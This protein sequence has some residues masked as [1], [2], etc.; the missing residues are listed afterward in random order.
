MRSTY[1]RAQS[2][3]RGVILV[4]V[5]A[6]L[7][8]FAII[9]LTFVYYAE[10][11]AAAS[12]IFRD[13]EAPDRGDVD[14]DLLL[15]YFLNQL[16]FDCRNDTQGGGMDSA[17]RGYG[18]LRNMFSSQNLPAYCGTGRLGLGATA[19]NFTGQP[20]PPETGNESWNP[21]YTYP[22]EN[23]M[24][25]AAV[26]ARDGMVLIPS[27]YRPWLG[28]QLRARTAE[29]PDEAGL[30]VKNLLDSPGTLINNRVVNNDSIWMDLNFPIKIAPDGTRYKALFAPLITDLDNRINLAVHGNIHGP[31]NQHV[32]NQGWGRWEV[33]PGR[34]LDAPGGRLP[35]TLEWVNLL[36]GHNGITGRYGSDNRPDV[37]ANFQ[38]DRLAGGLRRAHPY[39]P[40]DFD[41]NA[42]VPGMQGPA[43]QRYYT[44]NYPPGYDNARDEE[45]YNLGGT[46][47]NHALF[48][49]FF[50]RLSGNDR[51]G[52]FGY[53][54]SN[55]EALLRYKDM[56]SPALTSEIFRLM[57][58]NF[59][60]SSSPDA[61]RRRRM[62]TT[63]SMDSSGPGIPPMFYDYTTSPYQWLPDAPYPIGG[64]VL[65][66]SSPQ[67]LQ[68]LDFA[69]NSE[70]RDVC[71][72]GRLDL[73]GL[74]GS[75][76]GRLSSQGAI[77]AEIFRRLRVVVGAQNPALIP[78]PTD[79][80][81]PDPQLDALR[82]LAQLAINIVDYCD[83]DGHNSVFHWGHGTVYGAEFPQVV[84]NEAYAE[85]ERPSDPAKEPR[86]VKVWVELY[87]PHITP[88]NLNNY[89]L[90]LC[91]Q[92]VVQHLQKRSN[93]RG[94]FRDAMGQSMAHEQRDPNGG[95]REAIVDDLNSTHIVP[96]QSFALLGSERV[97]TT[98]VNPTVVS[99]RMEYRIEPGQ[100]VPP[101]FTILLQKLAHTGRAHDSNDNPWV[102]VDYMDRVPV[103]RNDAMGRASWGREEPIRANGADHQQGGNASGVQ[104]TFLAQ[105]SNAAQAFS[106]FVHLDRAPV[107]V[108]EILHVTTN[109]P[110]TL[111]HQIVQGAARNPNQAPW[112]DSSAR[113]YRVLELFQCR[114]MAHGQRSFT[115]TDNKPQTD[116]WVQGARRI[117]DNRY[118]IVPSG[119]GR[120]DGS[121][122][123][124]TFWGIRPGDPLL[125]GVG[126]DEESFVRVMDTNDRN[127]FTVEADRQPSG[128][129]RV[130]S[131]DDLVPGKI[132]INTIWDEEIFLA[133][134]DPRPGA[135][136][137]DDNTARQVFQRM[138]TSRSPQGYPFAGDRP[139]KGLGPPDGVES[140]ILRP[141]VFEI[142]G[143]HEYHRYE[144]LT[145]IHNNITT[146]SNVFA[147]WVTVGFFEVG[148][149]GSIGREI[150][151]AE[152]RHVRHRMFAIIDRS[153]HR[154]G[155]GTFSQSRTY[156]SRTAVPAPEPPQTS[157][158]FEIEPNTMADAEVGMDLNVWDEVQ[159]PVIDPVTGIQTG[160]RTERQN[161]ET[162][163]IVAINGNRFTA[164]FTRGHDVGFK[165]SGGW[166]RSRNNAPNNPGPQLKF[167]QRF[168][169]SV[170]GLFYGPGIVP[171]YS[172]IE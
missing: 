41:G 61:A 167:N 102:T 88:K 10:S 94:T 114:D 116:S 5:M 53:R 6:M 72:S 172:I 166:T 43:G 64:P 90:V 118:R 144:L 140:T 36:V 169:I 108:M 160:T 104:H 115:F 133:L 159:V 127:F 74:G 30:D 113:I 106:W 109:K 107:S 103:Y 89:R 28:N 149:D 92:D 81:A 54:F 122:D 134:C 29:P 163:R 38:F 150:G 137:F 42:S 18:L 96:P 20:Q 123:S 119:N 19:I 105:N 3:R 9:G 93:T 69:P 117:G 87:N 124:G 44:S 59:D 48:F 32:S 77:A 14:P 136:R 153:F 152:N 52:R 1:S 65:P 62:V 139:F 56:G 95:L 121:G 2:Q 146:R 131:F 98:M 68:Q 26:R 58:N 130:L 110:S 125:V 8:L 154:K 34:V 39:A 157:I 145:K 17:M 120:T 132:N 70:L 75:R 76:A 85:Y 15:S 97:P 135:N 143:G 82:W 24:F 51:S 148:P 101:F 111:T 66:P 33:N 21:S 161:Q 60:D 138:L 45:L 71:L 25:L 155:S 13:G 83:N 16:I 91:K 170:Q 37:P 40:V 80:E 35:G 141:G 11:E 63:Y 47:G 147:V 67:Q 50:L 78:P 129:I 31:G 23:N 22:D 165:L 156:T 162:V 7:T 142:P 112:T 49:N 57:P 171:Y 55:M 158:E 128:G 151:R 168:D 86:T 164:R 46:N 27:F 84:L 100:P 126:T 4:V 12:R 99:A 79:P 73:R